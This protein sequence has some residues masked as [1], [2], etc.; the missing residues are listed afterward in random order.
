[1]RRIKLLGLVCLAIIS[2]TLRLYG[3]VKSTVTIT[4]WDK[5][6]SGGSITLPVYGTV[7]VGS[8]KGV[9]NGSQTAI[10]YCIDL[11]NTFA[12]NDTY[13][14]YQL[15][16]LYITY[17]LY[18][19]Y[20][21]AGCPNPLNDLNKEAQATQLAIWSFSD[22]LDL[23]AVKALNPTKQDIVD[24]AIAIRNETLA[25]A[26]SFVPVK[27]VVIYI[28][29][30]NF[31]VG[32]P[33]TFRVEVYDENDAPVPNVTVNLATS[34]GT[35]SASSVTTNASGISPD[36]ILTPTP[37]LT[38]ANITATAT[39][40][41]PKGTEF[42]S[43]AAPTTK[44][45]L[46]LATPFTAVKNT[47]ETINW[48]ENVNLEI[49]KVA[50][51]I[52]VNNGDDIQYTIT[53]KNNGS[54][55]ATNVKVLDI[56]PAN[57][58][59]QS[60][61]P[62]GQ[63]NPINGVWTIGSLAAGATATLQINVKANTPTGLPPLDLGVAKDFNVFVFNDMV[64]SGSDTR[65]KLAVGN[66]AYLNSYAVGDALPPNSGDVLVVGRRLTFWSGRV[67]NG[68][69]LY[70]AFIDTGHANLADE[71]LR[72]INSSDP[73]YP[74]ST[75]FTD[76]KNYLTSLSNTMKNWTPNGTV[77]LYYNQYF[78]NGTSNSVNIFN[79]DGSIFHTL[80]NFEITVPEGTTAIVNIS[81][82]NIEWHNGFKIN[83]TTKDKVLLNFYDATTINL[84]Y[85]GVQG[86]FLAPKATLNFTS[87]LID[88]QVFVNNIYG[89][90]QYNFTKFTGSTSL[91]KVINVAQIMSGGLFSLANGPMSFAGF[92][93][94]PT[95]QKEIFEIPKDYELKQN[96]PN[97]FN[98]STTI[99][100]GIPKTGN[101]KINVYNSIGIKVAELVNNN[102]NAG[103]HTVT[104]DA[105]NYSSGIY[106][107]ELQAD[108]FKS[109]KKMI[110]IK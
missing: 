70:G 36:V 10:F 91:T 23:V 95:S 75:Y 30:Q 43:T 15:T 96:Y 93:F 9:Y 81:G 22:N 3:D 14:D 6:S 106:F 102:F 34:A 7:G 26:P 1:M 99:K 44:Q 17:I 45:K 37:G 108:N 13:T 83:G 49:N 101:V 21:V 76:A 104:F 35:L 2:F 57:V 90:G 20:P 107:Y 18:H 85:I 55:T 60:S 88:G 39:V 69:A 94:N 19:Y 40:T 11:N 105:T 72:K 52:F 4:G 63:Y 50:S 66:D 61:F 12:W 65:G 89:Q 71:G 48:L 98:P 8:F 62:V 110:L 24:R 25:G 109:I 97:P 38:S 77:T 46:V 53:V 82:Q 100:F 41:I 42:R 68:R 73:Y 51:K 54:V 5:P 103:Y 87:G 33:I 78:L 32:Q 16:N 80:T 58:I 84:A 28:P 86:V 67:Y 59:Y 74:P 56:L 64:S 92:S 27:S 47:M 31:A 29:P 79:V